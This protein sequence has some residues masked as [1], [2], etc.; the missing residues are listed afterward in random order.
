TGDLVVSG[1]AGFKLA[2]SFV[3][4]A[5]VHGDY[6][7]TSSGTCVLATSG[8]GELN[9]E[10]HFTQSA[11]ILQGPKAQGYA[12]INFSGT[13]VQ[14]FTS[15]GTFT[16]VNFV[17]KDGATLNLYGQNAVS[18]TGSFTVEDQGTILVGS[19]DP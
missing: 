19:K 4:T 7:N 8:I 16:R 12:V 9:V 3:V 5:T 17:V 14:N 13:S 1:S 18:G 10:G 11:G 6:D 15:G 2:S